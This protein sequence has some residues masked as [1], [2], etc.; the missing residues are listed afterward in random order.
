MDALMRKS[1]GKWLL[2]GIVAVLALAAV[3]L[4]GWKSGRFTVGMDAGASVELTASSSGKVLSAAGVNDAGK[5]LL[6]GLELAGK[7]LKEAC[8]EAAGAMAGGGYITADG[9]AVLLSVNGLTGDGAQKLCSETARGIIS[10]AKE[11][12]VD[13]AVAYHSMRTANAEALALAEEYGVSAGK[14]GFVQK[15]SAL[16]PSNN[17]AALCPLTVN[18]LLLLA[19][20]SGGKLADKNVTVS[21]APSAAVCITGDQAL[22]AVLKAIGVAK[23]DIFGSSAKLALRGGLNYAVTFIYK[24]RDCDYL[25]NART[26]AVS[27]A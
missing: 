14:A 16:L 19:S 1:R 4:G 25:V 21:G 9:N 15:L 26:G 13:A 8:A 3:L 17:Y 24:G 20:A 6:S 12:G 5:K 10:A 23:A 11:R 7:P 18:E 2:A 27:Q 22:N